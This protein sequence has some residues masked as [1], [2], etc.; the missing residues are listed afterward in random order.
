MH[1]L[2]FILLGKDYTATNNVLHKKYF[3]LEGKKDGLCLK[4]TF[5]DNVL[6][7]VKTL[8]ETI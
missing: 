6:R 5:W 7:L 1:V 4:E 2:W 8:K 3:I